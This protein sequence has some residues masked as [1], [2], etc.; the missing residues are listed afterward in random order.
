MSWYSHR[1]LHVGGVLKASPWSGGGVLSQGM[2]GLPR[3]QGDFTG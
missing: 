1:V 3:C 2:T